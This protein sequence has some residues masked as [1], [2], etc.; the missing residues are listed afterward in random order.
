MPVYTVEG[1]CCCQEPSGLSG[2]SGSSGSGVGSGVGSGASGASGS[3]SGG[4]IFP[5]DAC[6][7]DCPACVTAT[8][9]LGW[10]KKY[11][12]VEIFGFVDGECDCQKFHGSGFPHP[13]LQ[14]PRLFLV[15]DGGC[16]WENYDGS[17][18][19]AY[20]GA[21][22]VLRFLGCPSVRYTAPSWD[23]CGGGIVIFDEAPDANDCAVFPALAAV[24]PLADCDACH[25]DQVGSSGSSGSGSGLE[26]FPPDVCTRDC[27]A[28]VTPD[29]P[30]G[31]AKVNLAVYVQQTLFES[32]YC[33]C[34]KFNGAGAFNVL[35]LYNPLLALSKTGECQWENDAGTVI[36]TYN[37]SEWQLRFSDRC[38][39]VVYANSQ[40][41]CCG[42][43]ELFYDIGQDAEGCLVYPDSV[44][45][46][47]QYT[48]C[49]NCEQ[50]GSSGSGGSDSGGSGSGGGDCEFD[51]DLPCETAAGACQV[52]RR[53]AALTRERNSRSE[54]GLVM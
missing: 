39:S 48:G 47:P 51:G 41:D 24:Y 33:D 29:N 27:E 36:F 18:V 16:Q 2:S 28:C 23:C 53:R 8:N 21:E 5:I 22:W 20:N 25:D 42:G 45:V 46:Q 26:N 15:H 44:I 19:F 34:E 7:R 49:E 11:L 1:T 4:F 54:N 32:D 12:Y 35:G 37:G 40:W 13:T 52:D 31:W 14:N 9:P 3:G 10:G 30:K 43:G 17:V 38:V 6:H 50:S